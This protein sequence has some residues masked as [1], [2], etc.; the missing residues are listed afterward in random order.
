MLSNQKIIAS[1]VDITERKKTEEAL[2]QEQYLMFAL[3]DNLPDHIYFKDVSSRFVRNNK[4]HRLSF[5]LT[6][7]NQMVGKSDFDF[8][9]KE[10]AQRQYDDEQKIIRTGQPINKEEFTVRNDGSINWYYSTKMPLRNKEGKIIGTFGISR[11]ITE[12]K[13]AEDALMKSEEKYRSLFESSRDVFSQINLSGIIR[14]TSP[15]IELLTEYGRDELIGANISNIYDNPDDREILVNAI[16]KNGEVRDY[17]VMFKTKRG[18][19]RFASV[20]ARLIYN[21]NGKPD[22]IDGVLRDITERKEMEAIR[23]LEEIRLQSQLEMHKMMDAPQDQLFDFVLETFEKSLQSPY[24]FIGIID[25]TETVETIL[26]WSKN[27]M[28]QCAIHNKP[29]QFPISKESLLGECVRQRKPFIVNSYIDSP[30]KKGTPVGHIA[31]ER[32][33]EVPVFEGGKIMAV[34]AVANKAYD[35]NEKDVVALTNLTNMLWGI[36]RR[37]RIEEEL[38]STRDY[39][40]NLV[41]YANAPIIVWNPEYIITRFNYAFEHLSGYKADEAIGRRL[42]F[43]FPESSKKESLAEIE[44]S[45]TGEH[46]ESVEIPILRKDGQVRIA[47]W[48]SAALYEQG[49]KTVTATIAQGQD[50]TSR[51]QIENELELKNEQLNQA[52]AEKDKFFSIIAHDLRSPFNSLLGFT[53]LLVD[54]LPTMDKDQIHKSAVTMRKSA[55]KLYNLLENLLEWSLIQRG[56]ISFKPESFI[57]LNGIVPIIDVVRDAANKKMIRIGYD[58][59]E[60]LRVMADAHMFTSLMSN[61]IFNAVKFTPKIG[62]ISIAAKPIDSKWV[63]ISVKDTGIGMSKEMIDNL[64]RLDTDTNRKGTEGESSTG[65]G[66]I[67]CKEFIEKH[68]GKLWMESEEGKGATFYFTLPGKKDASFISS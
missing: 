49:S 67:I 64:F 25:E 29:L 62:S 10:V 61:L 53:Q 33:M 31:I 60:G 5:D 26:A 50:I 7:P 63:E 4:A 32:F 56:M 14:D 39:L 28:E 65:L 35:Y 19:Q 3:M 68:G 45:S 57:L 23:E 59:P 44:I 47:L 58:I 22:H 43:L 1:F 51:K 12:R 15:S 30:D 24:A 37:K 46:W 20:N 54:E 40:D 38:R 21:T 17:E 27:V 16:K 52:N 13:Q 41:N 6:D 34:S 9:T 8:F 18:E 42:D 55:T 11:D 48:N 36:L 66:L 2:L